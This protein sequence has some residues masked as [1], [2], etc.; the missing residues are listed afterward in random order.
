MKI[1]IHLHSL[2]NGK[3]IDNV[4]NDVFFKAEDNNHWF[5]RILYNMLEEDLEKQGID[6]DHDGKISTDEYFRLVYNIATSSE[7]T[8]GFV[9]LALDAVYFD[10]TGELDEVKTDLYV[11]NRFLNKKVMELNEL[12]QNE[13]DPEKR[14]KKFFFGASVSPNRKDWESELDYV[15]NQTDAVLMKWIPSTQHIRVADDK[16]K[17]F[18]DALSSHSMPLLCHVGPEYSFPEGIR[19]RELDNFRLL[20]KPLEH[21]VTV[22]A[23][24]CAAPVFP[25]IDKNETKEFYAFMERANKGGDIRLWADISALSLATR[26]PLIAEIVKTFPPEWLVHGSDFPLPYDGWPHLP[27]VT[28]DMS[29]KEF[30]E[31][32]KTKNPLDKDVKIKRAHGFSDKILENTEKVLRL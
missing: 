26:I 25:L 30:I 19:R 13:S 14:R 20:D 8:D 4:N 17:E 15:L 5:T 16:H 31:I 28:H 12:L 9:L 2:G 18:Y 27:W 21:E 32:I 7:E 22:I 10:D 3:D 29:P 24:H 1:D 23:A 6:F 11:S